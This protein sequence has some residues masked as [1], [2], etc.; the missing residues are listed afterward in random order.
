MKHRLKY[1]FPFLILPSLLLG[2][3]PEK[4]S[5]VNRKYTLL[6]GINY[7]SYYEVNGEGQMG[8]YLGVYGERNLAFYRLKYGFSYSVRRANIINRVKTDYT[9]LYLVT[10]DIRS[11]FHFV[12]ANF[13]ISFPISKT[14]ISYPRALLGIGYGLNPLVSG[15][16]LKYSSVKIEEPEGNW[17]TS[18]N[19]YYDYDNYGLL[20]H[21]GLEWTIG[22]NK[23][24]LLFSFDR[25]IRSIPDKRITINEKL[26]SVAL[27][28]GLC[29]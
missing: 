21:G 12:E 14:K 25:Y 13:F 9:G 3:D 19:L 29:I 5:T 17:E 2:I 11:S 1:L 8:S 24:I 6:F 20:Y 22:E 27:V 4:E 23:I 16:Y 10:S 7:S 28:F 26:I 18:D 15:E